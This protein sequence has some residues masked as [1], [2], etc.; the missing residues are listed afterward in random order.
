VRG[1]W[2]DDMGIVRLGRWLAWGYRH[3]LMIRPHWLA[4]LI[5]KKWNAASCRLFGHEW[6]SDLVQQEGREVC[7]H[8]CAERTDRP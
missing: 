8:C 1:D 2:T 3:G 6:M 7:P 5:V 4:H